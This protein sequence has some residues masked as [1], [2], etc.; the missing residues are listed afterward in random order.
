MLG[1]GQATEA[2]QLWFYLI[3]TGVLV[4]RIWTWYLAFHCNFLNFALM[5][6]WIKTGCFTGWFVSWNATRKLEQYYKDHAEFEITFFPSREYPVW[7]CV[8]QRKSRSIQ[9][10]WVTYIKRENMAWWNYWLNSFFFINLTLKTLNLSGWY[11]SGIEHQPM[12]EEIPSLISLPGSIPCRWCV[13]ESWL[14]SLSSM[15]LSFYPSPFLS[16]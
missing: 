13:G 6:W 3:E 16:F 5:L 9:Q 2:T 4:G 15:F 11:S 8:F 1:I 14:M 12:N 7:D 10:M